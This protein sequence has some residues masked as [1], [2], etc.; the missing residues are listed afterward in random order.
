MTWIV[1]FV[2]FSKNRFVDV[3]S[4]LDDS[5]SFTAIGAVDISNVS[6]VKRIDTLKINSTALDDI[7]KTERVVVT[8]FV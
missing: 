7:L 2:I 5:F 4:S 6:T 1:C 8:A 3:L